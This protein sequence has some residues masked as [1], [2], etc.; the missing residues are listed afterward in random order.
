MDTLARPRPIQRIVKVRRDYNRWVADETLEDYALRFA[1]RGFRK[2]SAFR[3]ANTAF[4]AVSFLALEAIGAAITL[5]YGFTNAIWAIAVVSAVIFLTGLPIS[6]RAARQGLDMDLLARGAGFGY[7]GST[8]TSLIYAGFTFIFFA[9]E[10]AIM[11]QA[12]ELWFEVPRPVGYV[13]SA[14]VVIPLVTHGVTLISRLQLW[15]QPVWLL[16][17]V[18]PYAAVALAD[19]DAFARFASLNG[20]HGDGDVFS[21]TAFGGAATVAASLIAQIGEQ[22]D[23][24]RFMP[25][26]TP[27]TRLRWWCAVVIAGPGWIVLGAAKMVGGAFLAF[28]ALQGEVPLERALEPTQMY[29]AGFTYVVGAGGLAVAL[30][31]VFVIVSQVKINVT[32]AYAGSLA[33][34]NFF[35]RLTHSHPGRVVWLM[36]NVAIALLLMGMGV[37]EALDRVLAFYA[38]LAVAWVGAIV[39]DLVIA[40]PLGLSPARIEFRRAYLHDI[41]P[42]GFG[43]MGLGSVLSV[44]AYAGLFGEPMRAASAGIALGVAMA[45]EPLIAWATGGRWFIAREPVDFGPRH[46]TLRCAVCRNRFESDDMAQCPAYGGAICSLCC[47]L[48][49]RCGDRCKDEGGPQQMLDALLVRL[50]PRGTKPAELRRVGRFV[51]VLAVALAVFGAMLWLLHTQERL[52]LAGGAPFGPE[53]LDL[54]FVK[55]AAGLGLVAAVAA[56]WLVLAAESRQVAQQESDRQNQLLQR[57]IDAHRHT[58]ALLANAKALAESANL[59][60][61]RFLT[62]MSHEMRAPLNSI[63]G[64]S[65]LLLREAGLDAGRRESV[66]TILRSGE[67]LA[68]LVDGLLELSRIEHGKLRLE[69]RPTDLGAVLSQVARM[70]E[71]LA[72]AKGLR[73]FVEVE[74]ALPA[75]VN[76]DPKRLRQVLINLLSNAVKFTAAGSVTLRVRHMREIGHIDVIDTGIG[77][78]EADQDRIFRPFER[79]APA[80]VEGTGLGLTI[81]QL[82]IELMG[83]DILV[84]SAPGAGSCFQVRIYLPSLADAPAPQADAPIAGYAGRRRRVLVVDDEPAHRTVLRRMLEPLGFEV[85]EADGVRACVEAVGLAAPDLVLLDVELPDGRGWQVCETL[86]ARAGSRIS[87]LMVSGHAHE[88]SPARR[89]R[90]GADGFVAKPV[91]EAD[92]LAAVGSCLALDWLRAAPGAAAGAGPALGTDAG[93]DAAAPSAEAVRELLALAAGGYPRALRARLAE[94]AQESAAS[95]AWVA[96]IASL[97]ESDPKA[98]SAALGQALA[99]TARG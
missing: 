95:A 92:L 72:E 75:R 9:L 66:D 56:W 2:W 99:E 98:L 27:R 64:Y 14:L 13:I 43:A 49:A 45:A 55:L 63:L 30:T 5:T 67:H 8:L 3:V 44:A 83:G 87:V 19:P 94:L 85:D 97:L 7:L 53:A 21:W 91:I 20:R 24:L 68:S 54:L 12:F 42:A 59:A 10:A 28:L 71:P 50:L 73:F 74:G 31:S 34:S 25:E 29:L 46:R 60:K 16:L 81:T 76:A 37:F 26:P 38:H 84:R 93:T 23:F 35:A 57:E 36:F 48:D 6:V 61:S 4:G 58:D 51:G 15:T 88:A 90:H 70:F 77:V 62:G 33:W 11:A 78:A 89:A 1:P 96:R 69:A 79:L 32:N 22:V 65:Q 52:H 41:N 47:T 17:L 18:L 86:R 80:S 82:L 39:G 40:K